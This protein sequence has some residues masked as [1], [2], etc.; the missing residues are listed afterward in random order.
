VEFCLY[1]KAGKSEYSV[2]VARKPGSSREKPMENVR[3]L[4]VIYNNLGW[5]TYSDRIEQYLKSRNDISFEIIRLEL[6]EIYQRLCWQMSFGSKKKF[7]LPLI[8]TFFLYRYVFRKLRSL[9]KRFDVIHAAGQSLAS[10]FVDNQSKTP[11]VVGMDTTRALYKD[12][13]SSLPFGFST[14]Q[15]S[16]RRIETEK[17]MLNKMQC[18]FVLS[19]GVK[20]SLVERYHI[21]PNNVFI[22]RPTGHV[23]QFS[24]T[25][26]PQTYRNERLK[27]LFIGDD[28]IRKGGERLLR[29]QLNGMH[30]YCELHLITDIVN[31]VSEIPNTTWYG[32]VPNDRILKSILPQMDVLCHPTLMDMS[33]LVVVEAACVG[34]PSI[35]SNIGGI[36]DLIEHGRT[37]FLIELQNEDGFVRTLK[38]LHEDRELL[39]RVSVAAHENAKLVYD[40]EVGIK[41][42]IDRLQ[43][44]GLARRNL[45][46]ALR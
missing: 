4:F 14:A 15:I 9:T 44:I 27:V 40:V 29:W 38:E 10:I 24:K 19:Q 43:A 2:S 3:I 12:T 35:A 8:D 42:V 17:R 13:F 46:F 25:L 37:G 22:N 26:L 45:K 20:D 36:A 32:R 31:R 5:R 39:Y 21:D 41:E 11:I 7:A 1:L 18:F 30:Q 28:F 23:S 16:N 34:V 6:P 33:A